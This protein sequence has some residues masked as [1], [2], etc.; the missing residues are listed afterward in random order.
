MA[1]VPRYKTKYIYDLNPENA[2][3]IQKRLI[4]DWEPA[5]EVFLLRRSLRL[6]STGYFSSN[7]LL[8]IGPAFMTYATYKKFVLEDL[9]LYKPKCTLC[10]ELKAFAIMGVTSILYPFVLT[11]SLN[12][13]IAAY[14]GLRVPYIY[15]VK[16]L[17]RFFKS[18]LVPNQQRLMILFT[19]NTLLASLVTY[20]VLQEVKLLER[21]LLKVGKYMDENGLG[22]LTPV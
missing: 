16:E 11:T 18:V 9:I 13:P 5:R 4:K 12:L 20:K 17:G 14:V 7:L 2:C 3:V 15:E 6:L 8:S 21:I 19:G 1:V 10:T 22:D